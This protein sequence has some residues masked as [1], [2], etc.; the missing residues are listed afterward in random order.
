MGSLRVAYLELAI[1]GL[2]TSYAAG[3][4]LPSNVEWI[5][6][7]AGSRLLSKRRVGVD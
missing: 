1:S 2:K 7:L 5:S 6:P 4:Y 3:N